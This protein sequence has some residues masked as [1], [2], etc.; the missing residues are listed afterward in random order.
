MEKHVSGMYFTSHPFLLTC[1]LVLLSH[2][3]ASSRGRQLIRNQNVVELGAGCGLPGLV[4]ARV[5]ASQVLLTDGNDVVIDLLKQNCSSISNVTASKLLWGDRENLMS[6]MNDWSHVDVVLAADVVQWPTVVE[7]LLHTV[8]ALLWSSQ[9]ETPTF[10]LGVVNR[11]QSTYDL[12]FDLACKLGFDCQSVAPETFLK[13]GVLPEACQEH[14]GQVTEV[15]EVTLVDRAEAP[16]LL[17]SDDEN[18]RGMTLGGAYQNT[19]NLPC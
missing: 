14:G 8:K 13:D 17:Q 2:Y 1:V 10:V 11:A 16:V 15:W 4:A 5:K 19:S 3:V 18:E 6:L 9:H 12:F 7:P